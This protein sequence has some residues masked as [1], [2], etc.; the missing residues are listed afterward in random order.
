MIRSAPWLACA[1]LLLAGCVRGSARLT[2]SQEGTVSGNVVVAVDEHVV[3]LGGMTADEFTTQLT[4]RDGGPPDGT[5]GLPLRL[6]EAEPYRESGFVGARYR[7]ADVPADEFRQPAG[8]AR[9]VFTQQD[10]GSW[11][12]AARVLERG[13]FTDFTNITGLDLRGNLLVTVTFPYAVE[14]HNGVLEQPNVVTWNVDLTDRAPTLRATTGTELASIPGGDGLP[15][16][17]VVVGVA[18]LLVLVVLGALWWWTARHR[19]RATEG[20][21]PERSEES[22][23]APGGASPQGE[24][25][26]ASPPMNR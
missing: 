1:L 24:R 11:Q 13:P 21:L 14:T 9:E 20:S 17:A 8:G 2:L 3:E 22:Q 19:G 16:A 6:A 7:F 10:D 25:G 26:T 18:T 5:M 4:T 15:W 23:R 12:F